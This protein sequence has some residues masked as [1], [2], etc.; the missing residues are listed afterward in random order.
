M[1][2]YIV[3][4][5][6]PGCCGGVWMPLVVVVVG[7]GEFGYK[8]SEVRQCVGLV[9]VVVVVVRYGIYGCSCGD[10]SRAR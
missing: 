6:G 10:S 7:V 9:V 2:G 3:V 5:S 4:V 1:S 8:C